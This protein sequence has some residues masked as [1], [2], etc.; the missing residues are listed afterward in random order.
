MK[1]ITA[2]LLFLSL[3]VGLAAQDARQR[4]VETLVA[5]VLAAMPAQNS[6][7]FN[8]QIADLAKA[9]PASVVE[10][11]GMLK[12]AAA[13]VKNNLVEYALS[14]LVNYAAVNPAVLENVSRGFEKAIGAAAST[15][16]KAFLLNQ[17]RSIATG[18]AAGLFA[19]NLSDPTLAPVAMG[20]LVDI[21]GTEDLLL[22][23]IKDGKVDKSLLA[24][25]AAEKGLKA[26]E[27]ILLQWAGDAAGAERSAIAAALASVGSEASLGFLSGSSLADYA[28][29]A[30]RLAKAGNKSKAVAKAARTLLKSDVSAYRSAGAEALMHYNPAKAVKLL[31]SALKSPDGQ[32]RGAVLD[33]ATDVL[34]VDN[35]VPLLMKRFKGLGD[36][37]KL[38]VLN[39][40]GN[41]KVKAATDLLIGMF[42][43]GGDLS[44]AAIAAAGKIGGKQVGKALIGQLAGD[45]PANSAAALDALKAFDGD[46]QDDLV[47]AI[48]GADAQ[49]ALPLLSLAS[50]KRMSKAAPLALNMLSSGN[51]GVVPYLSG[52]VGPGDA[53]K[54]AGMVDALKSGSAELGPLVSVFDAALHTLA[55]DQRYD[56]INDILSK[57]VNKAYFYPS[58]GRTGTDKAVEDLSK[59]YSAGN[60][61]DAALS[62]LLLADNYKAAP[63]LLEIAKN[64]GPA[65]ADRILPRYAD[66]VSRLEPN[67]GKQR[68]LFAEALGL[69]GNDKIKNTILNAV[70][71]VATMKSFLLAGKYLDNKATAYTAANAVKAIASKTKEEINYSDF[72]AILEKAQDAFARKGRADDRYAVDEIAKML[73]EAKPSPISKLTP[74]EEKQGFEM[75]FDGTSLDKWQGNKEGYTPVNGAMFVSA[76]YGSTGN[77]YT[78]KEY[79]NFVYRFEFCFLREGI[80]NGVGVRTP[81]GV[82]AA[83]HGMCEV[84]ILDHDAPM[85]ANLHEYQ[86]HG[87]VYGVIPAKRIVHKPLGE[88]STEEIRVE[89]DHIKVTVNGEVIVDGNVRQ[90]CKG[91]NVA[92]DGSSINPY[93]VDRKNHPGMFNRKG[94]ISFCGHGSGLKIRNVRILDL[95]DKK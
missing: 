88:W 2:L 48:A 5:D 55:P 77:L 26:A 79:R 47:A 1:K 94:Y 34:G 3:A 38:D 10:L 76:D 39:W 33:D 61:S 62:G 66:L 44:K 53:G 58:L 92:P 68:A 83:Y 35:L 27:P 42:G 65:V 25:A 12:P 86:V 8:T 85:Y 13:G 20:A 52:L 9:A 69:T 59:A 63:V 11:A 15:E 93:T 18:K 67:A 29:L 40:F 37:A 60:G 22:G 4:T 7:V 87:S 81:M 84:Q 46:L 90:A 6:S 41:N 95:G 43:A 91:H 31:S 71:K 23:L 64:A 72:K 74:E 51:S 57:A 89:G 45:N 36:G 19:D 49:K 21:P 30:A 78:L 28:S 75:L 32:Y 16:V 70:G 73:N 80:N 56:A 17:F 24:S 14:G 54:V 50:A 82:D